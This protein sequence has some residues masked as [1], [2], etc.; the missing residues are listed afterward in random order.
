MTTWQVGH[1]ITQGTCCCESS[2]YLW[3]CLYDKSFLL[4]A[5]DHSFS[6]IWDCHW[7]LEIYC[8]TLNERYFYGS[9]VWKRVCHLHYIQ[10]TSTLNSLNL[11]ILLMHWEKKCIQLLDVDVLN[12]LL[13]FSAE[14]GE[15]GLACEKNS[16]LKYSW[17]TG[18]F[19]YRVLK[20]I[21]LCSF[22]PLFEMSL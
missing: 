7:G 11:D 15:F 10:L 21:I 17:V 16:M 1:H 9:I 3:L 2:S 4:C 5:K 22:F 20:C 12:T 18:N 14:C 13:L 6:P 19:S 8:I